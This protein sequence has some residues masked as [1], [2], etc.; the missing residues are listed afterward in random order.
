MNESNYYKCTIKTEFED[1]KGRMKS[2]K[3]NYIVQAVNPTDV[4]VKVQK[5]LEMSDYETVSISV[6][7]IMD[8]IK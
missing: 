8:I 5:F 7:N 2:R 4:E 1:A 3:E 6:L